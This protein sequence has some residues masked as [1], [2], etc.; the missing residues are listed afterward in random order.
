M[1]R[2]M[3]NINKLYVRYVFILKIEN[4]LGLGWDWVMVSVRFKIMK[5]KLR[6]IHIVRTILSV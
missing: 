6:I 3:R 4:K 1:V 2:V 5:L